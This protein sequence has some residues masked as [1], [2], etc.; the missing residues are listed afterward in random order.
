QAEK[1][2]ILS[3]DERDRTKEQIQD[4]TKKYEGQ[5]NEEAAAKE[6]EIMEE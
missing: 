2:K 3:E 6:K 1:Q 5:V 4:L